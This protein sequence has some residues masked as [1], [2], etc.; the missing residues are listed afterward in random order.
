MEGSFACP[1]CGAS[2][3]LAG[4]APGR[5]VRCPFCHRFLEVPYLPRTTDK[6]SKRR[7]FQKPWWV[8]WAWAALG[9]AAVI[10]AGAGGLSLFSA[11][12]TRRNPDRCG[13]SSSLQSTMSRL[14]T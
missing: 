1:E 10:I 2:V 14:A 11:I 5:Q 13:V 7:R 4:L 8:V 12:S 6:E 9:V 3:E